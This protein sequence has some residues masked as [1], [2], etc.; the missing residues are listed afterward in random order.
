MTLPILLA[1]LNATD[2][3]AYLPEQD[4]RD[5]FAVPAGTPVRAVRSDSCSYLWMGVPPTA[6]QLREALMSGKR[7]PPR[8]NESVT[9]RVEPFPNALKELESRYQLLTNGYTVERDGQPLQVRPQKLEWV[10]NVG[11]KAYWIPSL[12]QLVVARKGQLFSL[13]VKKQMAKADLINTA[14]TAAQAILRR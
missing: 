4:V 8:A 3:C 6:A 10:P 11:E 7:L 1:L 2:P 9:L 5:I 12:S 13:V 14:A